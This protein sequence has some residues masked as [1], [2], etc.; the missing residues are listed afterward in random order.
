M[1]FSNTDKPVGQ[2]SQ[3]LDESAQL[4]DRDMFFESQEQAPLTEVEAAWDEEAE[5]RLAAYDCGE[6]QA[7]DGEL[8]LA[9]ARAQANL[10]AMQCSS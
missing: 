3:T 4:R 9:R 8:V 7:V 10:N 1:I 6:V 5:R 2:S